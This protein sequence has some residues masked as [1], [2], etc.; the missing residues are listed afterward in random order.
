LHNAKQGSA[1]PFRAGVYAVLPTGTLL[2]VRLETPLST[3]NVRAG[4]TF[5][6]TMAS[7]VVI[8]GDT[9]IASGAAVTGRVESAESDSD[10]GYFRL[11]LRTITVGGE[12]FALR[13]SN[14]FAR[15]MVHSPGVSSIASS[16]TVTLNREAYRV[17]KGRQLTFRLT[18]P[19]TLE[20]SG[21]SLAEQS[22]GAGTNPG[23]RIYFPK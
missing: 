10:S 9:L 21:A 8:E 14:L 2:T 17:R 11:T 19:V 3:T 7:P 20:E 22:R 15:A 18:S 23:P 13:T 16:G 5:A 1:I 6:A 4:D 12:Q